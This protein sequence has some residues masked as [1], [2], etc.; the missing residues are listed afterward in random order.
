N[1]PPGSSGEARGGPHLPGA[2]PLARPCEKLGQSLFSLAAAPFHPLRQVPTASAGARASAAPDA[3]P[4]GGV[5]RIAAAAV[6]G[7]LGP[8]AVRPDQPVRPAAEQHV[9]R[10]AGLVPRLERIKP[11]DPAAARPAGAVTDAGQR[12]VARLAARRG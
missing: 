6:A 3:L 11:G 1:Q 2:A 4:A 5:V 7:D 9:G 12:E 10:A 8:G